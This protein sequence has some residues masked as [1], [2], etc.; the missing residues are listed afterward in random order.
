M[1]QIGYN[2]ITPHIARNSHHEPDERCTEFLPRQAREARA[3][4]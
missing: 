3:I 1:Y 4:T 2:I